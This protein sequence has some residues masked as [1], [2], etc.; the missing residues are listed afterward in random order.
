M[1]LPAMLS[2]VLLAVF[3]GGCGEAPTSEVE[4]PAAPAEESTRETG[5]SA[6]DVKQEAGEALDAAK[7][8]AAQR[9]E[10]YQKKMEARLKELDEQLDKIRA[11]AQESTE[12]ARAALDKRIEELETQR[13]AARKKLDEI[14]KTS[15]EKWEN[16]KSEMD[17]VMNNLE[18]KIEKIIPSFE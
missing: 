3:L 17:A 15:A 13:D 5:V 14:R 4:K 7:T 12:E 1:Q 10:E 18:E 2:A 11:D 9:K 6:T 8:Y 16:L